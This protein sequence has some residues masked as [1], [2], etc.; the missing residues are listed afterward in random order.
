VN[1]VPVPKTLDDEIGYICRVLAYVSVAGVAAAP[2]EEATERFRARLDEALPNTVWYSG[3]D[4]WYKGHGRTPLIWP[5]YD[6]EHEQ[7][8]QDLALEDLE[9]VECGAGRRSAASE[10]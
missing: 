7:L 1:N 2:T 3:C 4:N 6:A 8:F 9:I 10:S 5:W